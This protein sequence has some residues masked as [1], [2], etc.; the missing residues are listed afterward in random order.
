MRQNYK[1]NVIFYLNWN[2]KTRYIQNDMHIK[3]RRIKV[4]YDV[5][6]RGE[7]QHIHMHYQM[8]FNLLLFYSAT[9]AENN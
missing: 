3:T 5:L 1:A 9:V 8:N 7:N 6:E 4:W 2:H